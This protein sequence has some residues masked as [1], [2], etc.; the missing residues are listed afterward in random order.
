M[1]S[2]WGIWRS[3]EDC[4]ADGYQL[5]AGSASVSWCQIF[6]WMVSG[7]LLL[8]GTSIVGLFLA[9][10]A[11]R[12]F[13]MK[14]ILACNMPVSNNVYEGVHMNSPRYVWWNEWLLRTSSSDPAFKWRLESGPW[15]ED[16]LA[17]TNSGNSIGF[18]VWFH[19]E[20]RVWLF[21][22]RT[23][24]WHFWKT[25]TTY[26]SRSFLPS[27]LSDHLWAYVCNHFLLR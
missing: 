26:R 13:K 19:F 12:K 9:I 11:P 2:C 14:D 20:H 23:Q 4:G 10:V 15:N 16:F 7:V 21:P 27:D 25:W 6:F 8:T 17:I 3:L 24:N 18:S 1:F 5:E 22:I